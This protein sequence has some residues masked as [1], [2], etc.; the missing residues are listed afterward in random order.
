MTANFHGSKKGQITDLGE[1]V[2]AKQRAVNVKIQA[3]QVLSA[4]QSPG[5]NRRGSEGW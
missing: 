3:S 1:L 4:E 2:M 5:G